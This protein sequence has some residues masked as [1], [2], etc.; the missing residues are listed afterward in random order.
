MDFFKS[1]AGER[2]G[3]S[4]SPYRCAGL[5]LQDFGVVRVGGWGIRDLWRKALGCWRIWDGGVLPVIGVKAI[6]PKPLGFVDK[7]VG[8]GFAGIELWGFEAQ[9]WG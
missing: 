9:S 3:S 7:Y 6:N 4:E 1:T 5:S 8:L 2:L